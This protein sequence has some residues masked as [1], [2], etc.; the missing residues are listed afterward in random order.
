MKVLV[1]DD[2]AVVREGVAAVLRQL[3]PDTEVLLAHDAASGMALAAANP[4]LELVLLDLILPDVVGM[5]ALEAFGREHPALPVMVLS[6]SEAPDAVRAALELGAMGYVPKSANPETLLAALRLVLSGEV[7][8]PPFMAR[9]AAPATAAG[10]LTE[11][12]VD[13]LRL[14]A[15]EVPNK[16]IAYRLG[17]SEKTVKAHLTAIFRTLGV[18][19]RADAAAA[20]ARYP[21]A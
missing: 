21:T 3:E 8:V 1:V 5:G 2:H 4:D 17:L 14:L 13:V 9:A 7:Y 6:S 18:S 12:Q 15:E 10:P 11:R 16:E 20:A 19:N